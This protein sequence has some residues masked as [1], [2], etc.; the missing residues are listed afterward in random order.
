V[1]QAAIAAIGEIKD[2]SAV[3]QILRFAQSEDWLVRQR[4]AE[5]LGNLPV[6]KSISALKYLQKDSHSHVSESARISLQRLAEAGV[7]E[8]GVEADTATE[9]L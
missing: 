4:L 5:A 6:P 1:Q 7:V 3:D 9:S 8:A 2:V